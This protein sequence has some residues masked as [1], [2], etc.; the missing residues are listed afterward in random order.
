[1]GQLCAITLTFCGKPEKELNFE[2]KPY[3]ERLHFEK[4]RHDTINLYCI[5]C[6]QELQPRLHDSHFGHGTLKFW[7][8]AH[9]FGHGTLDFCRVNAKLKVR[10]P[11]I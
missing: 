1:M 7:H 9:F 6:L 3:L 11:K 4:C 5:L 8:A 10:V 2:R